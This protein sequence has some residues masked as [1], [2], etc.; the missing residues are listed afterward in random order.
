MALFVWA[1]NTFSGLNVLVNNAGIQRFLHLQKQ[2]PWEVMD[3]EIAVNFE[4][5]VHLSSLFIPHLMK[6]DRPA[7]INITS[8]LSFVPKADVPIYCATKA[9][10]HSFTLSLRHQLSDTPISVIEIIPPAVDTDLG[11]KG[12]H[13]FGVPVEEFADAAV[14]Q[15]KN[16]HTEATY[17]FSQETR[18][19]SP[20][21]LK[22]IFKKMNPPG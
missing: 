20:D 6:Q 7:I 8:G 21:Q 19:A 18:N 15:L 17:G 22:A 1:T 9:A 10:M 13:T 16:D 4:A 2:P 5:P 3:E 11:G 14:A 12:L